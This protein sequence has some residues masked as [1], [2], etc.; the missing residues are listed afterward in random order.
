MSM[1]TEQ[2]VSCNEVFVQYRDSPSVHECDRLCGDCLLH[3]R[4]DAALLLRRLIRAIRGG[5]ADGA[6]QICESADNFLRR[7]GLFGTPIRDENIPDMSPTSSERR[8]G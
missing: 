6:L 4:D 5:K 3:Q 7:K 2:C 8:D 1:P